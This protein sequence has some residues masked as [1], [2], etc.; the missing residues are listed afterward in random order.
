[1]GVVGWAGAR[2]SPRLLLLSGTGP[3]D[4]LAALGVEPLVDLRDVGRNLHDHLLSPVIVSSPRPVPPCVPGV[5]QLHAH[6]FWRSR[7]GL[8]V[9]DTQ[10]LCFHLPLYR[11]E[12]TS[13][14]PDGY[15]LMGGLIRVES[16]RTLPLR[17]PDPTVAPALDPRCLT[18]EAD[19]DALTASV[20]L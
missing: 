12:D 9:P 5:T 2:A 4:E 1:G 16:R 20:E 6:L 7:P 14:P 11:A 17:S 3:A 10:P 18:A 15:T 19:V 8:V 13:G